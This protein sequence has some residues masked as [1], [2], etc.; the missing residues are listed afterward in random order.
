MRSPG[1]RDH[2][3]HKV[4]EQRGPGRVRVEVGGEVVA[5][6]Q[7]VIAVH[8]DANPIRYYFPRTDVRMDHLTPTATSSTCPYK[9]RASYF[10][11][12]AGGQELKD[13]AWSYEEPYEEHQGLA[14]RIAFWDDR[15]P[16]G[17]IRRADAAPA[18][19]PAD[20]AR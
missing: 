14:G 5:D 15:F 11:V 18:E 6:S 16:A 2:P 1:H 7:D 9:G 13:A 20:G 8:E 19:G 17:A 3:A 10:A 4:V 12:R